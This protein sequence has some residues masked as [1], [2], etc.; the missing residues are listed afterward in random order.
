MPD[1]I[2]HL[3]ATHFISRTPNLFRNK[4]LSFYNTY[5]PLIYLGTIFPDLISK[6]FAFLSWKLYNFS[7]AL[8]SPFCVI[9][10]CFVFSRFFYT[11]DRKTT[12]R[13]MIFFSFFHIFVDSLQEGINP[14]YQILYPFSFK[15]YG[16]NLVSSEMYLQSL[17]ILLVVAIL[18]ETYLYFKARKI[19]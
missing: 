8:H 9:I 7:I 3:L 16:F 14:G 4:L 11:K 18:I 2:T 19:Q 17:V 6:P 1:L 12:F 10:E 15:R 13:I 5:R